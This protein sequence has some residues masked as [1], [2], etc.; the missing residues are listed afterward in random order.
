MDESAL[1]DLQDRAQLSEEFKTLKQSR[2]WT[3][4]EQNVLDKLYQQAF[5]TFKK[6]DPNSPT[7]IIQAQIMGKIIDRIR[8]EVNRI[9]DDG[10][11]ARQLLRDIITED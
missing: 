7:D 1:M 9:I 10:D 8:L 2:G 3:L 5:E 11:M 4:F 6:V